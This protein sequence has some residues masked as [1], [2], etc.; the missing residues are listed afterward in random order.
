MLNGFPRLWELV[1]DIVRAPLGFLTPPGSVFL[2]LIQNL[3]WP[4]GCQLAKND[5]ALLSW[6]CPSVNK[7]MCCYIE[8][9]YLV[10]W[11][12]SCWE[13]EALSISSWIIFLAETTLCIKTI[14]HFLWWSEMLAE[15]WSPSLSS[16]QPTKWTTKSQSRLIPLMRCVTALSSEVLNHVV[17]R[18]GAR[19]KW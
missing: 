3:I 13:E 2:L 14:T 15:L 7:Y 4:S 11:A 5:K 12:N 17:L 8:N 9:T 1:R 10:S 18:K 6:R 19:W 16:P